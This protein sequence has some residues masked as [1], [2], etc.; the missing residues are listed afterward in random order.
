MELSLPRGSAQVGD[1]ESSQM[2]H[3]ASLD[4]GLGSLAVWTVTPMHRGS[5]AQTH[6]GKHSLATLGGARQCW[7]PPFP[8]GTSSTD[9][10]DRTK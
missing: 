10:P 7:A 5:W 9:T 2:K 8:P 3:P 6:Q 1:R 4:P